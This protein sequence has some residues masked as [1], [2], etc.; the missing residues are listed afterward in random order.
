M[1]SGHQ[2]IKWR[3]NIA[4]NFNPLSRVHERYRQTTDRQ[5]TDGRTTTYSEHEHEFTFA[6]NQSPYMVAKITS[7]SAIVGRP[8]SKLASPWCSLFPLICQKSSYLSN[9]IS[10][11]LKNACDIISRRLEGKKHIYRPMFVWPTT[12]RILSQTHGIAAHWGTF[13]HWLIG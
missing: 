9:L 8:R 10:Y 2:R 3:R 4:E 12:F 13:W 7:S 11:K 5:T 1:S 6:K